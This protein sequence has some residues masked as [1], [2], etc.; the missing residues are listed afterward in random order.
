MQTLRFSVCDLLWLI[1]TIGIA[2]GLRATY[3]YGS[4]AHAG[5][6]I[7]RMHLVPP[8]LASWVAASLCVFRGK[9]SANPI[10]W[11]IRLALSGMAVAEVAAIVFSLEVI[12]SVRASVPEYWVF[13]RDFPY[14]ALHVLLYHALLGALIG[15]SVSVTFIGFQKLLA[16]TQL[17]PKS[18]RSTHTHSSRPQDGALR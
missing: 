12:L 17:F 9:A 5:E 11:I 13:S 16:A 8:I 18:A 15:S 7:Q 6:I 10:S 4:P 14:L 2:L 3:V 1:L